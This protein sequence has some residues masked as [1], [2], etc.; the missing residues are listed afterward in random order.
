MGSCILYIESSMMVY[1]LEKYLALPDDLYVDDFDLC[2]GH[3]F[4]YISE[5]RYFK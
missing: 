3:L 4:T 1:A 5:F 2:Q